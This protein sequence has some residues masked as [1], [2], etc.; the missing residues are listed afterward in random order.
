MLS[1]C[2]SVILTWL[3]LLF[4]FYRDHLCPGWFPAASQWRCGQRLHRLH[5]SL[6]LCSALPDCRR[7]QWVFSTSSKT[8]VMWCIVE[9]HIFKY[10]Q[11]F[12]SPRGHIWA[13]LQN[14]KSVQAKGRVSVHPQFNQRRLHYR[15]WKLF[16]KIVPCNPV[17]CPWVSLF[18]FQTAR[19]WK[20]FA[21]WLETAPIAQSSQG[22]CVVAFLPLAIWE[23]KTLRRTHA[24]GPKTWPVRL[25]GRQDYYK[26]R[27]RNIICS[28]CVIFV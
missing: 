9:G 12:T 14:P 21:E 10:L 24:G 7:W 3:H 27:Y 4:F 26:H 13:S 17:K 15:T 23:A 6:A 8:W 16:L 20:M 25:G 5:C 2:K 28:F 19:F 22:N 11:H 18:I 1:V